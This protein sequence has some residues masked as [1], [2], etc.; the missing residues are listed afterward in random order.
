[1]RRA[2]PVVLATA[3]GLVLV[4][5][6]HTHPAG[7]VLG[8]VAAPAADQPPAPAGTAP[9]T[10]APPAGGGPSSTGRSATAPDGAAP[11][12]STSTTRPATAADGAPPSS[13]GVRTVDGPLV[14]TPYGEV[15]VEVSFAGGRLVDVTALRLPN[16]RSRSARLSQVAGPQLRS[17]A[18]QAQDAEIDLVSG[19][20]YTS[21]AYVESLQGALDAGDH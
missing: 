20:T 16:D 21:Q 1:M 9:S 15:Q 6:F 8:T 10:T 2:I 5:N 14:A 17:E 3:G 13:S 19:A 12:G 7:G 4:A 11:G 18:L